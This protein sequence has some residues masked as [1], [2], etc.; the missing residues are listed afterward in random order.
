MECTRFI[1][2]RTSPGVAFHSIFF[3][4]MSR[5][6]R[7]CHDNGAQFMTRSLECKIRRK[8]F[9]RI[10]LQI[11]RISVF[12]DQLTLYTDYSSLLFQ[13]NYVFLTNTCLFF[14]AA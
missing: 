14:K 7:G 2:F 3:A 6:H 1:N 9:T 10:E 5:I 13:I 11:T 12:V 8:Y 4:V